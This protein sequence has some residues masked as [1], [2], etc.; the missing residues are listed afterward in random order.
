MCPT[1]CFWLDYV[2]SD[3]GTS[4]HYIRRYNNIQLPK[5]V[6]INCLL[7]AQSLGEH[8]QV[9][10]QK[11][12][13]MCPA[14]LS[15]SSL[16]YLF[17]FWILYVLSLLLLSSLRVQVGFLVRSDW[18]VC[19]SQEERVIIRR[20]DEIIPRFLVRLHLAPFSLSCVRCIAAIT[21]LLGSLSLTS[22]AQWNI[23]HSVTKVKVVQS[24]L[25]L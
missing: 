16:S 8:Q 6:V 2:I 5:T 7:C 22:P 20:Q 17:N 25:I 4:L 11:T 24:C 14:Q 18:A 1:G 21:S 19:E 23:F 3:I 12:G 13:D 9:P 15:W 10:W